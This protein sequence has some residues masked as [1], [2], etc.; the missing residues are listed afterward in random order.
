MKAGTSGADGTLTPAS[1]TSTTSTSAPD[2]APRQG[3]CRG[4]RVSRRQQALN[5]VLDDL[6]GD[7]HP[8][9]RQVPDGVLKAPRKR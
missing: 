6:L 1:T 2:R 3:L 8:H 9:R 7:D 4:A 5:G